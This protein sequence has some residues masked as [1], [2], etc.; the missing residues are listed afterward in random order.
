MATNNL[1][2]FLQLINSNSNPQ[3]VVMN[4][5]EQRANENPIYKNLAQLVQQGDTARIETIVKNI[6]Q[7]K[8]IDYNKEFNAFQKI[9]KR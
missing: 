9:F 5:L 6:A 2:Q 1:M 8:G 7:E 3:Q 4:M